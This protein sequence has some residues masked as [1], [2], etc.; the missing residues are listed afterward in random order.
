[1]ARIS[2]PISESELENTVNW[3]FS[4]D[5]INAAS[6]RVLQLMDRL[7]LPKLLQRGPGRSH[8]SSDGQKFEVRVDSLNA[9]HSFKYFGK[10]HGVSVYT[11]RDERDLLW[12]SLVF[13][14]AERE[15][16][17]VIDGLMHNEV[18]KSDIHSTD[19]FGYTEAIFTASHLTGFSYAPRFKNLNDSTF[20]ASG[21][22]YLCFDRLDHLVGSN[23][24]V[25]VLDAL[26]EFSFFRSPVSDL[27]FPAT[28][29]GKPFKEKRFHF[30]ILGDCGREQK[31]NGVGT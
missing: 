5:N 28:N 23:F 2:H 3:F 9:N 25:M 29:T 18:V 4:L 14:A 6:D 15:S 21:G 26:V 31:G 19:A 13:S 16:A 22:H 11:F 27:W 1:M 7:E 10:E 24:V 12:H 17:Y 8:T 20:S 30:S